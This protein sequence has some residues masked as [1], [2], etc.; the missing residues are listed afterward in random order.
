MAIT[1]NAYSGGWGI[2]EAL[3]RGADI[4]VCGRAADAALVAGRAPTASF[5]HWVT[6]CVNIAVM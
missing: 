4:V 5:L 1:A 3:E 2:A 6:G